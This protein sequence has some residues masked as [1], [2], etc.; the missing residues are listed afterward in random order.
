MLDGLH[1]LTWNR[2]KKPLATA[3]SG[4]GREL[5]GKENGGDL[6]NVQY[7]LIWNWHNKFPLHNEYN[8]IKKEKEK[9]RRR[10]LLKGLKN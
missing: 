8:L 10:K 2:T 1:I 7:K 4:L 6:S 5:K 3:L 9:K